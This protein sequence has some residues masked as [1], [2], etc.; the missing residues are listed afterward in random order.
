MWDAGVGCFCFTEHNSKEAG[1]KTSMNQ[2]MRKVWYLPT[3]QVTTD[4]DAVNSASGKPAA[5]IAISSGVSQ[6]SAHMITVA[7]PRGRPVGLPVGYFGEYKGMDWVPIP[8]TYRQPR[9]RSLIMAASASRPSRFL[10]YQSRTQTLGRLTRMPNEIKPLVSS[11]MRIRH[12]RLWVRYC[13]TTWFHQYI[14]ISL[15]VQ[16][17]LL[18]QQPSPV[19]PLPPTI[20]IQ[21]YILHSLNF[22]FHKFHVHSTEAKMKGDVLLKQILMA[23]F[24]TAIVAL[25]SHCI[26]ISALDLLRSQ[27]NSAFP[28]GQ[29]ISEVPNWVGVEGGGEGN[30][31]RFLG[32]CLPYPPLGLRFGLGLA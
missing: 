8:Y 5:I 1:K 31:Y 24:R 30:Q 19:R 16:Y 14:Y 28:R 22:S 21:L 10:Y 4:V 11:G 6:Q 13:F 26:L 7:C 9:S 15:H 18:Q 23:Y 17:F 12:R 3:V 2:W 29:D 25:L 20:S 27:P 32:T